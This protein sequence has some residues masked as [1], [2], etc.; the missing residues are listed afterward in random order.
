MKIVEEEDGVYLCLTL[1]PTGPEGKHQMVTTELLGKAR[2]P[3]MPFV[4]PE[5]TPLKIDS[6]YLA[7]KRS[8]R[9]P[10]AGPFENPGEGEVRLKVWPSKR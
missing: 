5:G 2:I 8:E 10:S 7:Q 9:N 4:N 3:D 6:D 1:P